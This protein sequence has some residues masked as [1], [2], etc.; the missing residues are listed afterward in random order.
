M[1]LWI[2]QQFNHVPRLAFNKRVS[3]SRCSQHTVAACAIH[4][5]QQLMLVVL[6]QPALYRLKGCSQHWLRGKMQDTTTRVWDIRQPGKNLAVLSGRMGAVRS[7]RFSSDGR[8][9]AMAEPADFVHVFDVKAG[10]QRYPDVQA[11]AP[12]LKIKTLPSP[13]Q[14][15]FWKVDLHACILEVWCHLSLLITP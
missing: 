6:Q 3:T 4:D 12:C 5:G 1:C 2:S 7:L 15:K 13:Q 14:T 9:L 11:D 8:F 10:F